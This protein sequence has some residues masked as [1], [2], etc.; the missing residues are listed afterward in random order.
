MGKNSSNNL[1]ARTL[2]VHWRENSTDTLRRPESITAENIVKTMFECTNI[3]FI[4]MSNTYKVTDL[5]SL[6]LLD[7]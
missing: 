1:K 6:S 5:F 2:K 4:S 7:L 3:Q